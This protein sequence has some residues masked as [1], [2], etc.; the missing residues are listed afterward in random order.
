MLSKSVRLSIIAFLQI[1]EIL[2]FS[3][4]IDNVIICLL[5]M[6]YLIYYKNFYTCHN[7]SQP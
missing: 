7:V 2:S 5:S 1:L 3:P 4:H 6:M